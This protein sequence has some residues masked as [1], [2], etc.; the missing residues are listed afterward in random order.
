MTGFI[1]L[2]VHTKDK[3]LPCVKFGLEAMQHFETGG[4]DDLER[5]NSY[6]NQEK[7]LPE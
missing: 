3:T 2:T 5:A 7:R 4:L 6:P 1:R